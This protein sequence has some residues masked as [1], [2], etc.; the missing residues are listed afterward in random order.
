MQAAMDYYDE[1]RD[2]IDEWIADNERLYDEG[3]AAQLATEE[4]AAATRA[5]V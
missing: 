4:K 1:Y 3:L 2:E 5:S